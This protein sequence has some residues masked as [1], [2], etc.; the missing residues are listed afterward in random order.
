MWQTF[1]EIKLVLKPNSGGLG[2]FTLY[3]GRPNYTQENSNYPCF[4]AKLGFR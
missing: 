2:G 3:T 1:S 4:C